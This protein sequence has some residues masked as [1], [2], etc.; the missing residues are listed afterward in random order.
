MRLFFLSTLQ[1]INKRIFVTEVSSLSVDTY[2]GKIDVTKSF[3][4][5][6]IIVRSPEPC[7]LVIIRPY[8]P[9]H[10][11]RIMQLMAARNIQ[12]WLPQWEEEGIFLFQ[13]IITRAPEIRRC[14]LP[15]LCA[16]VKLVSDSD[17]R[18]IKSCHKAG[19]LA[20][21]Q[22]LFWVTGLWHKANTPAHCFTHFSFQSNTSTDHVMF[23]VVTVYTFSYICLFSAKISYYIKL[24]FRKQFPSTFVTHQEIKRHR[25][26]QNAACH[27]IMYNRLALNLVNICRKLC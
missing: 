22:S 11:T 21:G 2:R 1:Q 10:Q 6:E 8:K 3:H 13:E 15:F 27:C 20:A 16:F 26:S 4:N 9:Q 12:I 18:L 7:S 19:Q 5:L 25:T 23:S 24:R 17:G 14:V